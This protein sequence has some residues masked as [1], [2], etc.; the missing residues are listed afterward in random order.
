MIISTE[1]LKELE[2]H[3]GHSCSVS[4]SIG[5]SYGY[6]LEGAVKVAA[7]VCVENGPRY[8]HEESFNLPYLTQ[9]RESENLDGF[10][11]R[12]KEEFDSIFEADR[13]I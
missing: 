13:H 11:R 6:T 4:V 3:I 9:L 12:A 7:V 8:Y 10:G 1:I 2:Q 5:R